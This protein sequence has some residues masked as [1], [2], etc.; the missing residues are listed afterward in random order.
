MHTEVSKIYNIHYNQCR[1]PWN[2][3]GEGS[4][5]GKFGKQSI[6]E[7]QVHLDHCM[8]LLTIWHNIR[9]D[10]ETK[11]LELTGDKTIEEGR[12]GD[13][14]KEI[15]QGHCKGNGGE[16]YLTLTGTTGTFQSISDLYKKK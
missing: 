9:T 12:V 5:S 14:K 3:I 1:K 7:D 13:Y 11:L 4:H 15:F 8:E 16:N 6:P 2:C 10:L